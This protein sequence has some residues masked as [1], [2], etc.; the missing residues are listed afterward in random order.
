MLNIINTF[1]FSWTENVHFQYR[2]VEGKWHIPVECCRRVCHRYLKFSSAHTSEN[3]V[4]ISKMVTLGLLTAFVVY[5]CKIRFFLVVSVSEKI[6][7]CMARFRSEDCDI[8]VLPTTT[9]IKPFLQSTILLL[10]FNYIRNFA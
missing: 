9:E 8:W 5:F 6:K 2:K 10:Y 1:K 4:A 7:L 3:T